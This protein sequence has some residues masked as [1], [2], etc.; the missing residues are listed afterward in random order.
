[1]FLV[2]LLSAYDL[3]SVCDIV[4][5]NIFS[6]RR[7]IKPVQSHAKRPSFMRTMKD[8]SFSCMNKKYEVFSSEQLVEV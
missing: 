3:F 1:M 4:S 2:S 8:N 5:P 6:S 7:L